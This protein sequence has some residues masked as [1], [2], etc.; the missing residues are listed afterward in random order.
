MRERGCRAVFVP[1]GFF[2]SDHARA[3]DAALA[4][5]AA[6]PDIAWFVYEEPIYRRLAAARRARVAALARRRLHL[7]RARFAVDREAGGRK[8]IAV[9]CYRSQLR[10]LCTRSGHEDAF[11]AERYW[12]I[13]RAVRA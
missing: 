5:L 12:R 4:L 2:H 3:S 1:A 8:R 11:R 7:G 9:A 13:D 6:A 10:A